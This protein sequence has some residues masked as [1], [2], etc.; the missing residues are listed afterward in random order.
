MST[1]KCVMD[2]GFPADVLSTGH[3]VNAGPTPGRLGD[4][5][6][7]ERQQRATRLSED[8]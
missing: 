2:R 8:V 5:R 6:L 1:V 3:R 7:S 4:V